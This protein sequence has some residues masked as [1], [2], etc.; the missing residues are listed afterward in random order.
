VQA[1]QE[2]GKTIRRI[3]EIAT[4][5]AA[6]V[7][8]QNAATGEIARNVQQAAQGTAEVSSSIVQ[9]AEGAAKVGLAS[10]DVLDASSHLGRDA[11]TLRSE[12]DSFL[13][14][15]KAA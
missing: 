3:A 6:A 2:I 15:I 1:V 5:I 9:V 12:V 14:R 7:D 13:A 11:E 10:T 8:E 4:G